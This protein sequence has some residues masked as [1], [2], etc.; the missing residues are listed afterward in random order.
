MNDKL[1]QPLGNAPVSSVILGQFA[2]VVLA[3]TVVTSEYATG[4]VRTSLQWVLGGH[5]LQLAK[6]V[7]AAAVSFTAGSL[8]A[9]LGRAVA[10]APFRSHA[11]FDPAKAVSQSLAMG[12]Y[13]A[14]VAVLTVGTAFALRTA[15]CRRSSAWSP[16][17]P[18]SVPDWV[19][20]SC[21]P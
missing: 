3:M 8:F 15:H 1:V 4:R 13:C 21:W 11:S 9:V 10:R 17:S 2:G 14:L 20:P 19:A 5:R 7:V 6:A 12:L 16:P 18:P